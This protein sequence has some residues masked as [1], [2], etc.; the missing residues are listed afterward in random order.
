MVWLE[1]D[2]HRFQV[3]EKL[4]IREMVEI[5]DITGKTSGAAFAS[6]GQ[7]DMKSLAAW[8]LVIKRRDD[9]TV[10]LDDILD[11]HI[12]DFD[13]VDDEKAVEGDASPPDEPLPAGGDTG[14]AGGE[15]ST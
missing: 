5:Q 10:T 9:P 2:G 15:G 11:V 1:I 14:S 6:L 3:P 8:M 4:T 13:I 7:G 12:G